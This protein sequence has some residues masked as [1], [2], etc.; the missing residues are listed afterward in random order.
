[1]SAICH[2]AHINPHLTKACSV[3]SANRHIRGSS[4]GATVTFDKP[5]DI[6]HS[7]WCFTA[8][9]QQTKEKSSDTLRVVQITF[10]V[11]ILLPCSIRENQENKVVGPKDKYGDEV[12][13]LLFELFPEK[14]A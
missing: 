7:R 9:K 8:S 4:G 10:V 11:T 14:S 3:F 5:H 12:T 2:I 1:M 13:Y 6:N